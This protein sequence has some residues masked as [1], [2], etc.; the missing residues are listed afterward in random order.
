MFAGIVYSVWIY[1]YPA[2]VVGFDPGKYIENSIR[3]IESGSTNH[4]S[5][6]FYQ[7][8]NAY[9]VFV[10][11]FVAVT[12]VTPRYSLIMMPLLLSSI[13]L[14]SLYILLKSMDVADSE[15]A[16]KLL[17]ILVL[18]LVVLTRHSF[19]PIPQSLG[20]LLFFIAVI[21]L[22][23][24]Q[25]RRVR[26]LL[27][28]ISIMM[29]YTHKLPLVIFFLILFAH[30]LVIIS[31][32]FIIAENPLQMRATDHV[33][34]LSFM[35]LCF[36]FTILT[37]F[38]YLIVARAVRML[39]GE[40]TR[41]LYTE[42]ITQATHATKPLSGISGLIYR[43]GHAI[44]L[45]A[46]SGLAWVYTVLQRPRA[47]MNQ[48]LVLATSI[49]VTLM[50]TSYISSLIGVPY[51]Y[52]MFIGPFCVLLISV[53]VGKA[54]IYKPKYRQI[55]STLLLFFVIVQVAA[56]AAVPDSP[57]TP[58]N[59]L[60]AKEISAREFNHHYITE[61]VHTDKFMALK[62]TINPENT[63]TKSE[64]KVYDDNLVNGSLPNDFRYVSIRLQED[65]L[66]LAASTWRLRWEPE[67]VASIKSSKI[68]SNG[69]VQTFHR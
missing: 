3:I 19:W 8:A 4:I 27:I 51:R 56:P 59:Y 17:S 64:Y 46:L 37:E 60:D 16:V 23:H 50:I 65:V 18:S 42:P 45:L 6:P 49:L 67:A 1:T 32:R 14:S 40:T 13:I 47:M 57:G 10:S 44:A 21:L 34:V 9:S 26:L 61:T 12:G 54:T 5:R 22:T 20:I 29:I 66:S 55:L 28:P 63:G 52:L 53:T 31:K 2:G 38:F 36:Q 7:T 41:I 39:S 58:N 15:V 33:L 24:L 69:G 68:Y 35:L 48:Y 43:Y 11:Q 62:P 30:R 25:D